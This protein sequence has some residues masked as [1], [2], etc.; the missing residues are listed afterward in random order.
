M[1]RDEALNTIAD[2]SQTF[3]NPIL[4]LPHR[5]QDAVSSTYLCMRAIDEIE[6]HEYLTAM[7]KV[8]LLKKISLALQTIVDGVLEDNFQHLFQG[9]EHLLPDVTMRI[10]EWA[11]LAPESIAPRIWDTTSAMAERVS[12]WVAKDWKIHD[13]Y[14]L[15]RYSFAVSGA[16][17]LLLSD[18]WSWYDG[19]ETD[20]KNAIGFG[21]FLQSVNIL[22][23]R[24][25]DQK[26][27]VDF[28]PNGWDEDDM[29][30]YA[31]S[32]LPY[33]KEYIKTISTVPIH[34]A[35]DMLINLSL[36]ALDNLAN[37]RFIEHD[38][39]NKP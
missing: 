17:G 11:L 34:N 39:V 26:R 4:I 32:Y 14:D 31:R 23:G 30:R 22:R 18:L 16:A 1:L 28:F 37:R 19:T 6:D 29:Q 12:Y 5:L 21:C 9:Y 25:S 7:E 24:D 38:G 15:E 8:N 10:Y 33:A 35:C 27:N 2:W 13:R 36:N 20:R 3:Y